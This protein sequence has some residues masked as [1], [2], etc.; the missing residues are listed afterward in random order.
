MNER[1]LLGRFAAVEARLMRLEGSLGLAAVP[2]PLPQESAPSLPPPLPPFASAV[3]KAPWPTADDGGD[4][5]EAPASEVM[6]AAARRAPAAGDWERFFGLA[7]L[8]RVGIGAL[9][10]A[11]VYFGQLGWSHL[12]PVAR[13]AL[14]YAAGGLLIGIGAWLRPRVAPHYTA[15][16]WG[17]GVALTYVAGCLASLRY[18]LLGSGAAL[19]ALLASAALGQWL[20]VRSKLE[21]FATI[22][23]AG[24]F[25]APVLVG[26]PSPEPTRF[27]A[28]LLALHT[29]SAWCEH[30]WS[31]WR[32][33]A[34]AV[35]ATVVLAASW[36]AQHGLG[37]AWSCVGHVLVLVL[38]LSAPELIA[39][40][41]R[42]P[43][44]LARSLL[45][46]VGWTVGHLLVLDH[47]GN[48]GALS[49]FGLVDGSALVVLGALYVPRSGMLGRGFA[50]LGGVLMAIGALWW[51]HRMALDLLTAGAWIRLTVLA[52]TG[53]LVLAARRW[54]QVG[55]LGASFAAWFACA[56]VV[57][58]ND[59]AHR[60]Q[61]LVA[62]LLPLLLLFVGRPTLAAAYGLG[63][64]CVTSFAALADSGGFTFVLG[65]SG[66]VVAGLAVASG[67][68]VLGVVTGSHRAMPILCRWAVVLLTGLSLLWLG[69]ALV[70]V[71]GEGPSMAIVPFVNLRFL[72][73]LAVLA[74]VIGGLLVVPPAD[75]LARNALAAV[76]LA[77][78]W[79]GGLLEVNTWAEHL[80]I[81]W[82]NV[83]PSLYTLAFAAV[84]LAVGFVRDRS[85]LRWAGLLGLAGA[86]VKVLLVDLASVAVPLRVLATGATGAILLLGAWAYA[87]VR[88]SGDA[89]NGAAG[90]D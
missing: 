9:V 78:T 62:L 56:L 7:V 85:A 59:P 15:M 24:A 11:A 45:V 55:E 2:E 79:C 12:G 53:A 43:L 61:L 38:G 72:G 25:A 37:S 47:A 68:A 17:G 21:T 64:A 69:I 29:W 3:A 70:Q 30:R 74:A 66:W 44:D 1:E 49:A 81:G 54:T 35:F 6:Q 63:L 87:R 90:G 71:R 82:A 34:L 89:G 75:R 73:M 28:L 26:E 10:L 67:L 19:A 77:L 46:L 8:G 13:T 27:F 83:A 33:R 20:A 18:E 32:A 51:G 5:A 41:Q 22:A 76:A 57:G 16:L 60:Y 50:R 86:T 14:V 39:A 40:W 4:E 42:R 23:L 52:A 36:Y 58:S 84:L 65:G 48:L 80:P 31:W 88:R